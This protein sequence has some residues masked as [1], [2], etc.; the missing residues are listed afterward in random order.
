V[1]GLLSPEV[2]PPAGAREVRPS[3]G[4]HLLD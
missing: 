1:L 3:I 4:A 2:P